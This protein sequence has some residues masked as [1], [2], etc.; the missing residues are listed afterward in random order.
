M[1]KSALID[2]VYGGLAPA[3]V[4]TQ[5]EQLHA[6]V[7][8]QHHAVL[9]EGTR[10]ES[11]R[12][13]V[14]FAASLTNEVSFALKLTLPAAAAPRAI[15]V[16]GDGCWR[17]PSDA[18][19]L[20]MLGQGV[21]LA[22]F[23]RTQIAPDRPRAPHDLQRD[24]VLYEAFPTHPFGAIAAW[25]WGYA[26]CADALQSMPGLVN[27]PLVFSGH[28]RGGK[29]AILAGATDAR[30]WL[31]HANNAGVAGSGSYNHYGEG[32]E[33][34][35]ALATGY[36]HWV[37]PRLR[38]MAATNEPL[39]FDQDELLAGMAPRGL[40]ITQATDDAWANP[41]GTTHI[42]DKL[43]RRY[44]GLGASE[45]IHLITRPG[46]HPMRDADWQALV[47]RIVA[48]TLIPAAQI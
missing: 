26:R 42:I 2:I 33:T 29:A 45:N 15:I 39:P 41:L 8:P 16:C 3:P 21:G 17:T 1:I 10:V 38:A 5:A 37:G 46:T 47:R 44:D 20:H 14:S 43:R 35:Q 18:A 40:L 24:A 48:T 30:A 25:A 19:L 34:W 6:Y 11:L 28:S 9:P 23:D 13:R 32:S 4:S 36:P 22:L 27:T 12:V 31:T 7:A